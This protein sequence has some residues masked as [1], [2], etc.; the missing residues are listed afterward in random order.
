MY[1]SLHN[2]DVLFLSETFLD[3]SF[4]IDGYQLERADHPNNVKWGGTCVYYKENLPIRI[5]KDIC[6]LEECIVC[7]VKFNNKECFLTS[8]YRSPSQSSDE[9]AS[10]KQNLEDT[11]INIENEHPYTSILTGD[12]NGRCSSWWTEDTDNQRGIEIES[13]TSF[14]GL[15]QSIDSPTH[16]LP[17][18]SSCIDLIF[19]SQLSLVKSSGVHPTLFPTCHHQLIYIQIDFQIVLPPPF[20]RK[21]WFYD[22]AD[23][24]SIQRSLALIDWEHKFANIGDDAQVSLLNEILLNI[25]DNFIPNKIINCNSKEPPWVTREVKTAYIRKSRAFHNFNRRGRSDEDR[26]TFEA[27]TREYADIV[28]LSKKNHFCKLGQKLNDPSLA[29]K[30]YWSVLNNFLG[31]KNSPNSPHTVSWFFYN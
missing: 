7:E 5:R 30:A 9:F 6:R 17:N 16:I 14:Y 3:S 23:V 19:C 28:D 20:Q 31:K 27:R 11:L 8:L 26:I 25:F 10:F 22:K 1:L 24:T 13:L 2:I 15:H 4:S 18:S 21:V 12:F 29:S